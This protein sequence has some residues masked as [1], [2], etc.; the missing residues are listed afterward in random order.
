MKMLDLFSGIG[1]FSLA[2]QWT[3]KIETVGFCE[4]EPFCQKLLKQ[5]F[6]GI[7]VFEDITK[8]TR[9]DL[10][11]LGTIGI[12]T[13]GFPCQ[14]IS[15]VGKRKGIGK[16]TRSG[17]F[18]E[19]SRIVRCLKPKYWIMENVSN[20]LYGNGGAWFR[21]VLR[22]ITECGYDAEWKI[23]SCKDV[24]GCHLRK[25]VWIIAT[26]TDCERLGSARENFEATGGIRSIENKIE[27]MAAKR[28]A[29]E[30]GICRRNDGISDRVDRVKGLG[31]SIVPQ[32]AVEL[33]QEIL[34]K[35]NQ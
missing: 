31:N 5:N 10:D 23:I 25:R 35:E 22:E 24:G 28:I 30:S 7:P 4:I 34:N 2:A 33:F 16:E 27:L 8:I 32:I 20:L 1:G 15:A 12:I 6:P 17:L 18:F 9:K 19:M 26:N 13:G 11:A 29:L 14:D 3:G 21:E